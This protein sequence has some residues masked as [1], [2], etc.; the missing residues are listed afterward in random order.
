[1]QTQRYE[2]LRLQ[3]LKRRKR[4]LRQKRL[5]LVQNE[6]WD[7]IIDAATDEE[8]SLALFMFQFAKTFDPLDERSPT[9]LMP[10]KDYLRDL[11]RL[12][13][14]FRY[15]VVPKSRQMLC[16]WWAVA[17]YCWDTYRHHGRFTLFKS[18]DR[19]H[20]GLGKLCLLWRARYIHQHL[21]DCIRARIK[22]REWRR[23]NILEYVTN[24]GH[25][26]DIP[27]T[28]DFAK[29]FTGTGCLDDELAAQQY[30]ESG[31]S[32]VM[33]LLGETG[34]YTGLSTYL[35]EEF[36]YRLVYDKLDE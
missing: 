16:T 2:D 24:E 10:D 8:E 13:L 6:T 33:P 4:Q 21:P 3:E 15:L 23:D 12:W 17:C 5:E 18:T 27:M 1:M 35:G 14:S 32:A 26:Q 31:F 11:N 36:F 9:K 22:I 7:R 20:S 28:G 29:T 34:R 19:M 25:T 30:G